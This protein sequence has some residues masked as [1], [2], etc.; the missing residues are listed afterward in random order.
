MKI[1]EKGKRIRYYTRNLWY[2]YFG[3]LFIP[4]LV[5]MILIGYFGLYKTDNYKDIAISFSPFSFKIHYLYFTFPLLLI[6]FLVLCLLSY[7]MRY[8]IFFLDSLNQRQ[9]IA[10]LI[11]NNGLY[12]GEKKDGKERIAYFPKVYHKFTKKMLGVVEIRFPLD[13]SKF[14]DRFTKMQQDLELGL[15]ADMREVLYDRDYVVY[16]L[17][18]SPKYARIGLEDMR[19]EGQ[20]IKLMNGVVWNFAKNPHALVVGGT[21]SGK[22]FTLQTIIYEL[23]K[24]G[25][26]VWVLDPKNVDL[27]YLSYAPTFKKKV[28]SQKEGMKN[29]ILRFQR[30]MDKRTDEFNKLANGRTGLNYF[31]VGLKPLFLVADEYSSFINMFNYRETDEIQLAMQDILQKG[32]QVGCFVIVGMQRPDSEY[33]PRGSRDQFGLRIA[34][35]KMSSQ[36]YS[37]MFADT[38]KKFKTFTGVGWG[39]AELD[40]S[41]TFEFWSPLV[42]EGFNFVERFKTEFPSEV[43]DINDDLEEEEEQQ[44]QEQQEE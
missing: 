27:S 18:I 24:R 41:E 22:T 20:L 12:V 21:G 42:P 38:T 17:L 5:I 35:R 28:F 14:Q 36:G 32:R 43:D 15:N 6:L 29:A 40:G 1:R 23:K 34:L 37:M 16:K 44:Q 26:E 10:K 31:D 4:F 30:L 19:G 11:V 3:F 9:K 25:A 2:I 33:L 13:M 39:Y 7:K 8:D